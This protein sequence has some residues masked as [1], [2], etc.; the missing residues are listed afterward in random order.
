M[1]TW[2]IRRFEKL[3]LMLL[4]KHDEQLNPIIN[5]LR[6]FKKNLPWKNN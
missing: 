3:E 1:E 5:K 6:K 2:F 4:D